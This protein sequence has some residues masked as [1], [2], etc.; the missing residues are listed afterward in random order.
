MPLRTE[1]VYE[2]LVAHLATIPIDI[3]RHALAGTRYAHCIQHNSG[4]IDETIDRR[5]F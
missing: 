3:R 2:Y 5:K 4:P 1:E